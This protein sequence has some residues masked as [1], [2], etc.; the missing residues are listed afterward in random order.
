MIVRL[1]GPEDEV[2]GAAALVRTALAALEAVAPGS[3]ARA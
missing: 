1:T 3:G 2:A